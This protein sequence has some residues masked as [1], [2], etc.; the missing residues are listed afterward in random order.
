VLAIFDE[1]GT[2][3]RQQGQCPPAAEVDSAAL[4]R[5]SSRE[6][7]I[8]VLVL[9]GFR[10]KE[11]AARLRLATS[12]VSNYLQRIYRKLDVRGRTELVHVLLNGEPTKDATE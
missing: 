9:D 2:D 6:R 1:P 12:T 11:I 8:A 3:D 10:D 7:E 4:E 5:L